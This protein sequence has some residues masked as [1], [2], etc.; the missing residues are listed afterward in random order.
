MSYQNIVTHITGEGIEEYDQSQ[1]AINQHLN[2]GNGICR[3]LVIN[4]LIA[5]KE[6]TNFWTDNRGTVAQ[7]LLADANR[8]QSAINLQQEYANAFAGRYVPDPTTSNTLGQHSITYQQS[9][10]TASAQEGFA[11]TQLS[12]E[13][14]KIANQ[15][16][17][18]RSRFF[19]LSLQGGSGC[20]SIGIYRPYA[21]IGKSSDAY[22]FDPNFGEFKVSGVNNLENLLIAINQYGYPNLDLN[23]KYILWSYYYNPI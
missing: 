12:N 8:T 6:N 18:A 2:I 1:A 13:P 14:Q 19:I 7:P 23:Q 22:L 9:D 20:H 5:K 16:L 3:A 15:V 21:L 17:S 11:Q 4:W 10:I